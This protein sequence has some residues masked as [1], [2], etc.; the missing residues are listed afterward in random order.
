[1]D[2]QL[3]RQMFVKK[4]LIFSLLLLVGLQFTVY[5]AIVKSTFFRLIRMTALPNKN[6]Y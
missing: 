5:F 4:L 1:M 6:I 3:L 2:R